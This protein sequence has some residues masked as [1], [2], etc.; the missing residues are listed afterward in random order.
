MTRS[1][2]SSPKLFSPLRLGDI[3]LS[4]RVVMAPLTRNRATHGNDAPN[5][6]NVRNVDALK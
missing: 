5:A 6:L 4:N 3:E 1:D 2:P